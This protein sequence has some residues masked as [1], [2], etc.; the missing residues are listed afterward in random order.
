MSYEKEL[1]SGELFKF[2]VTPDTNTKPLIT[3]ASQ[4][5]FS[6]KIGTIVKRHELEFADQ[7]YVYNMNRFFFFIFTGC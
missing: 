2:C 6:A 3:G 7:H 4:I 5:S 1:H